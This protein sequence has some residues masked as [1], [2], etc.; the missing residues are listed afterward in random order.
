MWE[1]QNPRGNILNPH[2]N[3]D[4][5]VERVKTHVNTHGNTWKFVKS[6]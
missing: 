1:I 5:H 2:G 4:F 3:E 6:R